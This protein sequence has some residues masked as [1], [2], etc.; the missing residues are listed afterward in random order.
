MMHWPRKAAD[1]AIRFYQAAISP[2]L[3][4]NCRYTPTCSQYARQAI[5][6]YGLIRGGWKAFR[7]ILRCNPLFPGGYD[8]L[9]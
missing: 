7:R 6:K 4:R 9:D 5:Q 2:M 1:F 8:P 3:G